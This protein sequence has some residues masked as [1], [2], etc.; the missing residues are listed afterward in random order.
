MVHSPPSPVL[1]YGAAG[2]LP[3]AALTL[4]LA[5]KNLI[6]VHNFYVFF[7][8]AVVVSAYCF[9]LR[10]GL[11]TTA[12][13][14]LA[15]TFFLL[16][17]L[18]TFDVS[19]PL[20][21]YYLILFVLEGVLLSI[22][23]SRLGS[24]SRAFLRNPLLGYPLAAG[25]VVTAL[26]SKLS[27]AGTL[28]SFP[29]FAQ[30]TPF[31]LFYL[32][33][34]ISAWEG[35]LGP[36]LLATGLAALAAAFFFFSPPYH[37]RISDPADVVRLGLFLVEGTL[38][39]LV[40]TTIYTA[41][42]RAEHNARQA[43]RHQERLIDSERR[44][45]LLVEGVKDHALFLL[46]SQGQVATWNAGAEQVLGFSAQE[47][48]GQHLR[49]FSLP[50]DRQARRPEEE[51]AAAVQ[52]GRY[53]A[54]GW[55][56]RRGGERFW[57]DLHLAPVVDDGGSPCGFAAVLR[58]LTQRRQMEEQVCQAQR[59]EAAGRLAAGVAHDFNNLLAAVLGYNELVLLKLPPD[60]PLRADLEGIIEIGERTAALTRQLL[61]F[62]RRQVVQPRSLDLNAVVATACKLLRHLIGEDVEMVTD[63]SPAVPPVQADP[64]QI[65]QVLVNLA[66]NARD[67]MPTG[68]RLTIETANVSLGE[69]LDRLPSDAPPGHYVVLGVTDTG[70]GMSEEVK[71][72]LF[73][74]LFTTK[75]V[76]KGTGLGLATVGSIVKEAGG[77]ISVLSEAG[78]GTSFRIFFPA[79]EV[80]A[81]A[82]SAPQA[83]EA[84][85]GSETVLL[86]EDED[87]LRPLFKRMLEVQGYRVLAAR[88]GS[89]AV[90][91]SESH[92]GVVHL[93]VTDVV[94]PHTNGCDLA[95]QLTST[96]PGLRVLYI[97]G[98]AGEVL[99]QRGLQ[100]GER[101]F[102]QKPFSSEGL[103]RKVREILDR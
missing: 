79:A 83:E 96:R 17:P 52:R 92:P 77:H 35:G 44:Y 22:L 20:H 75:E 8:L 65:E 64:G 48:R 23:A 98:Y 13:G 31:M 32:S 7:D 4:T 57:A 94:M 40:S 71:S 55:R 66:V 11:L 103:A 85:R 42:Q 87:L 76:G 26:L 78:R 58:D 16:E 33:I 102:L 3:A 60:S 10:A 51:L 54:T 61:T 34:M 73:E 50:A 36:G 47:V 89:E 99:A 88:S 6:E 12:L 67:A 68:G 100:Q 81:P 21:R 30:K 28:P 46:D 43:Q 63:L 19:D 70:C 27:L 69:G 37:L 15:S 38:I 59:M 49:L 5:V 14:A 29:E 93:L 90:Q 95:A 1:R 72:H 91:I 86:V 56:A 82:A 97:S 39:A 9:G 80:P 84:P 62:T 74:P 101:D 24:P 53:E 45:R 18:Y 25:V 2:L 41:R